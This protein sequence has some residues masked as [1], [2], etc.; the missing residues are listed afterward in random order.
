MLKRAGSGTRAMTIV[1]RSGRR[2][3][4]RTPA[5]PATTSAHAPA[6]S[7]TS[8]ALITS[9]DPQRTRLDM[10]WLLKLV[11]ALESDPEVLRHLRLVANPAAVVRAGRVR[12]A[13]A[14]LEATQNADGGWG[15]D[16]RSYRDPAWVGRGESTASQTAW[17][18]I[19]LHAAGE[20]G[21][22]AA[23]RG[24]DWLC[25]TQLP[26]GTWDEPHY[27]GTGFPGDFYINYHLYRLIFP[28][29]ALGRCLEDA[30][31]A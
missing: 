23:R 4:C 12:R 31:A 29:M 30:R 24:I 13:V 20:G 5:S 6:A 19:A 25:S 14:W 11:A 9:P 15:E 26:E 17:A 2:A 3:S 22:E 16:C 8:A 18:L 1:R 7:T 28:V 10:G 21:S 27:T